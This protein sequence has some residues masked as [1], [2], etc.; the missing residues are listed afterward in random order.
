MNDV[1]PGDA[2]RGPDVGDA[3]NNIYFIT[4]FV[5]PRILESL[6]WTD[7][8]DLNM[9]THSDPSRFRSLSFAFSLSLSLSL[10]FFRHIDASIFNS[11]FMLFATIGA[12]LPTGA[13]GLRPRAHA[14]RNPFA[15]RVC[16]AAPGL[17]TSQ[18]SDECGVRASSERR[19]KTS[20]AQVKLRA[21]SWTFT[22]SVSHTQ[23]DPMKSAWTRAC[24]SAG[25]LAELDALLAEKGPGCPLK[26]LNAKVGESWRGILRRHGGPE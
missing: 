10:S 14:A 13:G 12:E 1:S 18:P 17:A 6:S 26:V 4:G 24:T 16:A 20:R 19:A 5:G 2:K 15:P 21:R 8:H 7:S 22:T 3:Q 25:F 23:T 11:R 9:R